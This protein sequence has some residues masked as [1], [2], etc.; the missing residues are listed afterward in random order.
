M[1]Y[2]QWLA[3]AMLLMMPCVMAAQGTIRSGNCSP[4]VTGSSGSIVIRCSDLSSAK[5]NQLIELM[6]KILSEH[7]DLNEVNSKLDQM[8]SEIGN[9]STAID[10]VTSASPEMK[11]LISDGESNTLACASFLTSM[12][13]AR[14]AAIQ[15]NT[16][17]R[18]TSPTPSA[19]ADT[20]PSM[21]EIQAEVNQE[22]LPEYR[23]L[24]LPRLQSLNARLV[25]ASHRPSTLPTNI[26]TPRDASDVGVFAA[27][28]LSMAKTYVND[29]QNGSPD[30]SLLT[31]AETLQADSTKFAKAWGLEYQK[32]FYE[33]RQRA[34]QKAL[35]ATAIQLQN[36]GL[37][38]ETEEISRYKK[39]LALRLITF[40]AA[41][42]KVLP[43]A[44]S[45]VDYETVTSAAQL[46]A[47]CQDVMVL[48]N[49]L[50]LKARQDARQRQ[51][52]GAAH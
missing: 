38:E 48:Q 34:Q 49:S 46:G 24:L 43:G 7:L 4:V 37:A 13:A 15:K 22:K 31:D 1:R 21:K 27:R 40:R 52:V 35:Q 23:K 29:K 42:L 28:L 2:A 50:Y 47:V 30:S 44:R 8:R 18:T 9:L 14:T 17:A 6:N 41:V 20:G 26:D 11:K 12:N 3:G 5:A 19:P 10:P 16:I 25:E 33:S 36:P 51:A 45:N 39:D 32:R